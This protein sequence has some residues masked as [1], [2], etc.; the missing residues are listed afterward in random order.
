MSDDPLVFIVDDD[1]QARNSVCALVQSMGLKAESFA[2]AEDFLSH[3]SDGRAGC[4]V[5][6]L[7]FIG[8]EDFAISNNLV[9]PFKEDNIVL[10]NFLIVYNYFNTI[11]N[12][13]SLFLEHKGDFIEGNFGFNFLEDSD[14]GVNKGN[15]GD[16][17][18]VLQ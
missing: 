2:S 14:N 7:N 13:G 3:Y 6:D 9:S 18:A 8:E 10:N 11:S 4:L 5:T 1:E 15:N 12:H 17:D 16:A